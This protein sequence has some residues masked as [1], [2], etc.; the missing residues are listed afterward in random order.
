MRYRLGPIVSACPPNS[1]RYLKLTEVSI[2]QEELLSIFAGGDGARA[3]EEVHLDR[4]ELESGSW[5][6]VAD[7]LRERLGAAGC[8]RY[9]DG[10]SVRLWH[11]EGAEMGNAASSGLGDATQEATP[12]GTQLYCEGRGVH[13]GL[14]QVCTESDSYVG[15]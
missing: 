3:W 5:A 2:G 11:L 4:V 12:E 6:T 9:A 8:G 14:F 15:G 13:C 10:V 1:L 7:R